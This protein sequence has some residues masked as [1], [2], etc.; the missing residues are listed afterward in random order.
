M[1]TQTDKDN[2]INS[3]SDYAIKGWQEYKILP[4]L[5]IAQAIL[6]SGWGT[7]NKIPNNLFG[8]KADSSWKGKKKLV[9]THEYIGKIK[10]LSLSYFKV[11]DNI[12]ESLK[13]RYN[14][15]SKSRYSKVTGESN[16]KIA[17]SEVYKAGYATDILYPQKLIQIIEQN[18]L[19]KIDEQAIN[20]KI[21]NNNTPS[22]WSAKAW[23]WV[24]TQGILDGTRYD[25]YLSREEASVIIKR[26][27]K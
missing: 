10:V 12:Y 20:Q 13:D 4:S 24:T 1:I 26:M 9:K 19:H 14:L 11:Y 23:N 2:F 7:S 27:V 21:V 17:C 5:T 6:E 25:D 18:E 8:T 16:Y 15:L 3:L 22:K